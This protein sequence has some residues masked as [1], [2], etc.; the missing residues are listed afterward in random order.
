MR[1]V[2]LFAKIILVALS[3]YVLLAIVP[4]TFVAGV[5]LYRYYVWRR[6]G[7]KPF[8]LK[9]WLKT[10]DSD[11]I[12]T[13][14]AAVVIA[15]LLLVWEGFMRARPGLHTYLEKQGK[16]GYISPYDVSRARGNTYTLGPGWVL[17]Q[18][19][20][21]FTH[22]I[23][24]NTLGLNAPEFS[25]VSDSA[26]RIAAFG[27]SFTEGVGAI[28][29]SSYPKILQ[30]ILPHTEVLN[31]GLSGSD[32]LFCYRLLADKLG[33]YK[34][35]IATFTINNTDV[36]DIACR[37]GFERFKAD[38]SLQLK[39]GPWW[40]G[41]FANFFIVRFISIKVMHKDFFF[42]NDTERALAEQRALHN[43]EIATDSI[44][45]LCKRL[46]IRPVF[47]FHPGKDEAEHGDLKCA[48]V[49]RY[50]RSKGY[51]T[52]DVLAYFKQHGAGG[53]NVPNYFWPID[54]H[55]NNR[56]YA[57][58]AR[59]IKGHLDSTSKGN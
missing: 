3:L 24:A 15:A 25:L 6:H 2:L 9:H 28:G 32:P 4:L 52:V 53:S 45:Y 11:F 8:S 13:A 57:L 44:S 20:P 26:M 33:K 56:G 47:V 30:S 29:D 10:A 18:R 42:L 1:A 34:P 7:Y 5:G 55:N 23:K 59:A 41:L 31:C 58:V 39:G 27:D 22:Y 46:N 51:E 19:S 36:T 21:E 17:E 43:L 35:G 54:G 50:A 12:N 16:N 14:M 38:G 40:E 49:M 48:E 37:G